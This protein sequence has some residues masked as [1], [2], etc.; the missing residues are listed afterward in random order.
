MG[1][2]GELG[3]AAGIGLCRADWVRGYCCDPYTGSHRTRLDSQAEAELRCTY[4]PARSD[5]G[6]PEVSAYLQAPQAQIYRRSLSHAGDRCRG[7]T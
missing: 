4:S 5:T 1:G 3:V 6:I 7:R 2:A